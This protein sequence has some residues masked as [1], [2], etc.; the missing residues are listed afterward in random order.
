M[1]ASISKFMGSGLDFEF[2]IGPSFSVWILSGSF[3]PKHMF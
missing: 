3:A 1:E 2:E